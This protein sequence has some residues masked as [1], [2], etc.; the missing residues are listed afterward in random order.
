MT[1]SKAVAKAFTPTY[2]LIGGP[3]EAP[4]ADLSSPIINP[5]FGAAVRYLPDAAGGA[6]DD[7]EAA[8]ATGVRVIRFSGEKALPVCSSS[9]V[10]TPPHRLTQAPWTRRRRLYFA[11]IRSSCTRT[12]CRWA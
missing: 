10:C 9:P 1:L 2:G 12:P 3:F 8:S 5:T 6:G 11:S 4:P 7:D